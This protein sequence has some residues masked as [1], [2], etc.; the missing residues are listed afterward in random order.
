MKTVLL[1]AAL[2]FCKLL[3]AQNVGIGTTT[4]ATKLE[5]RNN[6]R[7]DIK[8]RSNNYTNDTSMLIFSNRNGIE[9]GTDFTIRSLLEMGLFFSSSSDLLANTS[10]SILVMNPQGRIGVGGLPASSAILDIKSTN[11]GVLIPRVTTAQRTA[12]TSPAK[13]LL[14]FDSNTESF[15]FFTSGGWTEL[16]S[17]NVNNEI[18]DADNNTKVQTEKNPN[19]DTIRFVSKGFEIARFTSKTLHID[20]AG[21][22]YIGNFAG[23]LDGGVD[24]LGNPFTG[25][26][27]IGRWAGQN[28]INGSNN[29]YVGYG[30][31]RYERGKWNTYIGYNAGNGVVLGTNNQNTFIGRNAGWTATG[32]NNIHVGTYAGAYN[33]G[34]GN[35]FI[36]NS[37]GGG[38]FVGSDHGNNNVVLGNNAGAV[39]IYGSSNN[40]LIGNNVAQT[41]T[42]SNR[43]YIHNGACD[44]T[45]ALVFGKFDSSYLRV[46]G[47]LKVNS[48]VQTPVRTG[49]SNMVPICYGNIAT[50][51]SINS[52]STSNFTASRLGTGFYAITI[53]GESYQFQTY[54]TVITPASSLPRMVTTG[55]GGGQLQVNTWDAGGVAAD[56]NFHFVVYKK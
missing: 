54:V 26:V 56:S 40:V 53:T 4:P 41:D 32:D 33:D 44:S 15:W 39:N 9:Q 37:T 55:S 34:T 49:A 48:E 28:S 27:G 35:V 23:Q 22:V 43:L 1:L 24:N 50:N 13:G 17:G 2:F 36:G 7:S 45:T 46:N 31:G 30:A 14:V 19:D 42:F 18:R 38:S 8:I 6:N 10:D 11:K 3:I 47:D 29:V 21:S 20:T 51:G 12:I 16:V 25:N 52:G 5:V